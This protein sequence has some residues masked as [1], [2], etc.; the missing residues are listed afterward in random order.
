MDLT[1]L[2]HRGILIEIV[3][4]VLSRKAIQRRSVLNFCRCL[5]STFLYGIKKR[6]EKPWFLT[7]V[8]GDAEALCCSPCSNVGT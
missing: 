5:M 2:K 4:R 1:R 7:K 3:G 8:F 6:E